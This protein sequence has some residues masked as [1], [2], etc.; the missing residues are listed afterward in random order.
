MQADEIYGYQCIHK[1]NPKKKSSSWLFVKLVDDIAGDMATCAVEIALVGFISTLFA[2]L[3]IVSLRFAADYIVWA[4]LGATLLTAFGLSCFLAYKF[5]TAATL[6]E[7][8]LFGIASFVITFM[9][10]GLAIFVFWVREKV[11]L[12]IRLFKEAA[13]ALA[14]LPSLFFLPFLVS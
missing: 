4:I 7:S 11:F 9:L 1:T 10:I 14:D 3:I 8:V 6:S 2:C 13:K 5:A 12:V